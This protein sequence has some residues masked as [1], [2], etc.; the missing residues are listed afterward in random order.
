MINFLTRIS[1]K[2]PEYLFDHWF[3][4][5]LRIHVR[6]FTDDT[7]SPQLNLLK[8]SSLQYGDESRWYFFYDVFDAQLTVY[9]EL[10]NTSKKEGQDKSLYH[11]KS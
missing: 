2:R 4:C 11:F 9:N 6:S 1:I 8:E 7:Y 3:R 5:P 10:A